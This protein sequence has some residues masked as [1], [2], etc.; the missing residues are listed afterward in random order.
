MNEAQPHILVVDDDDR[1]RE[2]LRKFLS[3]RGFL[4]DTASDAA[5]ARAK[6]ANLTFDLISK[7]EE[8]QA[9]RYLS[10]NFKC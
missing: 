4:V 8:G 7:G 3:E 9:Q 2:L 6:L 1:L 10:T 5:D